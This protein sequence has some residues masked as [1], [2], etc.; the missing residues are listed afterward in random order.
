MRSIV[1]DALTRNANMMNI[2]DEKTEWV[3]ENKEVDAELEHMLRKLKTN[4]KIIGCGG[5]NGSG[6]SC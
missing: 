5:R 1:Q 4:I 3:K 6:A 2:D